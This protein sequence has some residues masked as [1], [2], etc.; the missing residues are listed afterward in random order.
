MERATFEREMM[1]ALTRIT[2]G[3]KLDYWYGYQHGLRRAYQGDKYGTDKE[4]EIWMGFADDPDESRQ[5]RGRGYLDGLK[6]E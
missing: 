5:E 1:R 6:V 2:A 3:D 4:H